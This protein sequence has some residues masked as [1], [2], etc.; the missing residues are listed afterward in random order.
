M[1][2]GVD[3]RS[4]APVSAAPEPGQRRRAV[5][6]FAD[7]D[8]GDPLVSSALS[9]EVLSRFPPTQVIAGTR[10]FDLSAAVYTHT[11]L[12]KIGVE[13]DLHV[14]EDLFHFFFLNADV[15]ESH[16]AYDVTVRFFDKHLGR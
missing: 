15:P 13:A 1:H 16:H 11:R 4:H 7:A 10:H 5:G 6:Y 12:I 9:D 14:W 3:R 8:R 2:G